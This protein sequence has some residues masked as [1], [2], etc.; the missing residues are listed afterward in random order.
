MTRNNKTIFLLAA[1][2]SG[3]QL[4]AQLTRALK[5]QSQ[6]IH[7]VGIG[8]PAMAEQ[9]VSSDFDIS[10]LAILGFTEAIRAYPVVLKKVKQAA[11]MILSAGPDAVV[12]I[13]SWGFMVRV[14][15]RLKQSGY[16]GKII[17]YVA[18]Q[19]WAMREG[20]A[21]ILAQFVDHLLSIQSFDAPYFTQHGLPVTFVGNPMF[22]DEFGP[23]DSAQFRKK[24]GVEQATILTV[25]FGS[26]PTEIERLYEPFAQTIAQ[27]REGYPELKMFAP[28]SDGVE[29]LLR[30]RA[31]N[32]PRMEDVTLLSESEKYEL[33]QAS[34]LALACS[35]TVTTQLR[36]SSR[37]DCSSL[38]IYH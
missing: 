17:K 2:P 33:F 25:L 27:L 5:E 13:D 4:G 9:G 29:K 28:V 36:F 6:D 20:R 31:K 3:D 15:K 16:S 21:R 10:P 7:T 38:I 14:A 37:N 8:G 24:H 26:R 34:D 12:L 11:D 23:G 32:D 30:E 19:V 18:P 35:G 1:E 22:D